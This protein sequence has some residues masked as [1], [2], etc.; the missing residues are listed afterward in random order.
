MFFAGCSRENN[1]PPTAYYFDKDVE[2]P[3][4]ERQQWELLGDEIVCQIDAHIPPETEM[5]DIF[6][7][8]AKEIPV[9]LLPDSQ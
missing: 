2:I 4:D 9:A 1:S 5:T 7:D 3:A 6:D 8:S